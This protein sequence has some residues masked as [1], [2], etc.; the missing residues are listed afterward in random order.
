MNLLNDVL[1]E[2]KKVTV[3][4]SILNK[5]FDKLDVNFIESIIDR[6]LYY[7]TLSSHKVGI[8]FSAAEGFGNV[9]PEYIFCDVWPMVNI[10][11][12]ALQRL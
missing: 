1:V 8:L 10:V 7:E 11:N 4:G 12:G 5:N 2:K 9:I 6:N 3:I